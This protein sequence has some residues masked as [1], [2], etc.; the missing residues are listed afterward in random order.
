MQHWWLIFQKL[1]IQSLRICKSFLGKLGMVHSWWKPLFNAW[2]DGLDYVRLV[3]AILVKNRWLLESHL[4]GGLEHVFMF[5]YIGNNH[6]NWLS[7]IFQK[8][9]NHQP[10]ITWFRY[11]TCRHFTCLKQRIAFPV[12]LNTRDQPA[13]MSLKLVWIDHNIILYILLYIIYML[14]IIY[15][16]IIFYVYIYIIT[17]ITYYIYDIYIYDISIYI[18]MISIYIY[19]IYILYYIIL[20]YIV[21]YY[22]IL[23]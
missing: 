10:A 7:H 18:Y 21:L 20:Y 6:P 22:I 3:A 23:Y 11:W 13:N 15:L 12:Q 19:D 1:W 2:T 4:V 8:G 5:P 17:C 9:W 16:Y 14:Y